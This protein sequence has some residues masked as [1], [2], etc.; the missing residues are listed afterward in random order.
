MKDITKKLEQHVHQCVEFLS[1]ASVLD[2]ETKVNPEKWSK[3]EILGH[4]IDSGINNLQRFTEIEFSSK[5]YKVV[6]YSQDDLVRVNDYQSAD[7]MELVAFWKA[8]NIRIKIIMEKQTSDTLAYPILLGNEE[9][10]DLEFLMKD[11]V[12]HLEHH[13]H[14]IIKE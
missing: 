7:I 9:V 14:Q 3:K 1:K 13:L 4:L 5:P 6:S 2:L 8:I 11:Y 12:E 10:K